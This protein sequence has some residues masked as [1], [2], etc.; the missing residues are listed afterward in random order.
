MNDACW[1]AWTTGERTA[2]S[3]MKVKCQPYRTST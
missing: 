3:N 2:A 1:I